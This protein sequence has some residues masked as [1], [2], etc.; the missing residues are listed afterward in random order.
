MVQV[1]QHFLLVSIEVK[2]KNMTSQT[3][4]TQGKFIKVQIDDAN[5]GGTL[6]DIPV[7][8]ISG[9]G[10]TADVVDVT[11]LQDALRGGLPDQ[12]RVIIPITGPY[13]TKAAVSA[14]GSGAAPALTG[15]HI[16]LSA[17]NNG[18]SPLAF[19]V[20][21]GI[22]HNWETNEPVF[23]ITGTSANGVLVRDYTLG[24]DGMYSATIYVYPGSATLAWGT[25]QLT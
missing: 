22:R 15:S 16:V 6:R 10:I 24:D 2:R 25:V 7:A 9:I 13:S 11:A 20:Y 18:S 12:G 3:G 8:T 4:R 17:I 21:I 19:G 1:R 5:S 23:G 14:S